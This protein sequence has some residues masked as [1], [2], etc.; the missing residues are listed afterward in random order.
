MANIMNRVFPKKD[1]RKVISQKHK[2][3]YS[4]KDFFRPISIAI[5]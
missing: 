5:Q 1:L 4:D 3:L 2:G